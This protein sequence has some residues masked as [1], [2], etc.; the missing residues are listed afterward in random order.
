MKK[1]YKGFDDY[2]QS[3]PN[4]I[5]LRLINEEEEKESLNEIGPGDGK[6]VV[7][8]YKKLIDFL[9]TKEAKIPDKKIHDFALNLGFDP[10]DVEEMIYSLLITFLSYGRSRNFKG[11]FDPKQLDAGK[12]VEM[13]HFEG[14][15]LKKEIL[16]IMAEKIARDHLAEFPNY[17]IPYLEKMEAEAK[18]SNKEKEG[19]AQPV[20]AVAPNQNLTTPAIPQLPKQG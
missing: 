18:A 1:T 11:N 5:R 3:I 10:D 13:E 8:N 2:L 16:E 17:Y 19:E 14:S 15:P 6:G 7:E 12:K 4:D 9:K 20:A